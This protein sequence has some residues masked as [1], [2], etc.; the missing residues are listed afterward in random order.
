M[1]EARK[2]PWS[3]PTRTT[4]SGNEPIRKSEPIETR[5]KKLTERVVDTE[6]ETTV[7][8]DTDDGG[9]EATVETGNTVRSQGLPVDID[10]TVEL[11]GTTGLGGLGVIGK[12]GSGVVERVDE[13]KGRGTSSTTRCNVTSKPLPVA[14]ALLETEEGLEVVLCKAVRDAYQ[15]DRVMTTH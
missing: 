12:T 5:R 3:A 14:V 4:G 9:D 7:D 2:E 10:Q 1:K 13:E 6:V 11:T 15:A 8:D